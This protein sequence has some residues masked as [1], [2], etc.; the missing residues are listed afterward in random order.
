MGAWLTRVLAWSRHFWEPEGV[1]Y[2]LTRLVLVR[3]LGLVYAV[4]FLVLIHQVLP[5]IG[6][7]GLLPVEDYLDQAGRFYATQDKVGFLE[8]P[9][10]FWW[11]HSDASLL[12]WAWV[13]F[14]V[15][16]VVLAGFANAWMFL[17]LWFIYLSFDH[18]GQLFYGY[19]WEAQLLETGFLAVFL[20]PCWNPNL[21]RSRSPTPVAVLWLYRWLL[22]RLMLGAGLIKLRHDPCWW[23]LTCLIHHYETQPIPNP[24][25]WYLHQLPE[26]V[27]KLGVLW[28]HFIEVVLPF[29]LLGPAL[30]RRVVGVLF[31][32]FQIMLILSGN[33]S[34]LNWLTLVLCI[35]CLDDAC[36]E[37]FV[38]RARWLWGRNLPLHRPGWGRRL[39]VT[40][41]VAMVVFLSVPPVRNLLSRE[42]AMNRS[43]DRLHLV[44]TYGAF[45]SVG[46]VRHEVVLLGTQDDEAD[47]DAVW[48]EYEFKAKPGDVTRRPPVVAPYHYRLDWQIWFA[49]MSTVDRQPWLVHFVAKL[50]E[51]DAGAL[52]LIQSSPFG[53]E[54]PRF[55]RA[56][57][58]RYSFTASRRDE[59]GWWRREYVRPYLRPVSLGDPGL[60][61]FLEGNGWAKT[62][63]GG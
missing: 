2:R 46:D 31:G 14:L 22:F 12:G 19:G 35:A 5:L 11:G 1:T 61:R 28:N 32:A 47:P 44:N 43:F 56:D 15:S 60:I 37:P 3:L 63:P 8:R 59:G 26:G 16:L 38:R 51:A 24:L 17:F 29:F 54:P 34:F 6:S 20:V 42:Q 36:W 23:D 13:G 49:A 58:Y 4:A 33:L 10:I 50:L 18:V 21:L 55:I 62:R 45:G 39:S 9:S 48:L 25:S 30:M 27:H 7:N 41:L 57:L 52:S 40:L 53:P